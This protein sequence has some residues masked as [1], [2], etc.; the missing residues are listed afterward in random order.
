MDTGEGQKDDRTNV[1][2]TI[3]DHATDATLSIDTTFRYVTD[4]VQN[5][6][7]D[8]GTTIMDTPG[9]VLPLTTS[10]T[11]PSV[12]SS[13]MRFDTSTVSSPLT[14]TSVSSLSQTTVTGIEINTTEVGACHGTHCSTSTTALTPRN[15][16]E[17]SGL[18]NDRKIIIYIENF[19]TEATGI[20]SLYLLLVYIEKT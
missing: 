20:L 19:K 1:T 14:S 7:F 9:T 3:M 15:V 5:R 17:V 2:S 13:T 16:T 11:L 8:L 10:P 18:Y 4:S 12:L 6:T